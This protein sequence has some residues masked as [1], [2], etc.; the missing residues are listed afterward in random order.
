MNYDLDNNN[1]ANE[2]YSN[3]DVLTAQNSK[4]KAKYQDPEE[5]EELF[6]D[7]DLNDSKSNN[8]RVI[9]ERDS[10]L[11]TPMNMELEDEYANM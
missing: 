3:L 2:F 8:D 6:G 7:Y 5:E 11:A 9:I 4:Q 1:K 10:K